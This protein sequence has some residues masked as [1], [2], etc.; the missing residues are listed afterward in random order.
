VG[1]KAPPYSVAES[2]AWRR[3][4]RR[5]FAYRAVAGRIIGS[6]AFRSRPWNKLVTWDRTPLGLETA[7]LVSRALRWLRRD[8]KD[9]GI[10]EIESSG[11][12][13]GG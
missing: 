11:A 12:A 6:A 4:A 9:A 1:G 8:R 5:L 7:L 10:P 2:P 13:P 3:S